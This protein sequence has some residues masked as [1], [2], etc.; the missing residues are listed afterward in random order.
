MSIFRLIPEYDDHI[1]KGNRNG[2]Y[3][4]GCNKDF[5][6]DITMFIIQHYEPFIKGIV[7]YK[8]HY[9]CYEIHMKEMKKMK[10]DKNYFITLLNKYNR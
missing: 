1:A 9:K 10:V 2:I 3:C 8:W 5:K 6:E 4:S 7:T